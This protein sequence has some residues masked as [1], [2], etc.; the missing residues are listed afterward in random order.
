MVIPVYDDGSVV[1]YHADCRTVLAEIGCVADHVITD[2]PYDAHTHANARSGHRDARHV[3][4]P[5]PITFAPLDMHECVPLLLAAARRWCIC[6]CSLEMIGTYKAIAGDRFVRAG[7]YRRRNGAPQFTGDRPAQ[8]GEG[9]A[10]SHALGRKR[11]NGGGRSG[12][13]ESLIVD[14]ETRTH[15]TQKPESLMCALIADFTD[16]GDLILDPFAGSGTTLVAAKRLGRRAIGIEMD[17]AYCDHI[18]ERLRQCALFTGDELEPR[19]QTLTFDE[20]QS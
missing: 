9:L 16:P 19:A 8:P 12:F 10:I 1:L 20:V 14:A 13:Y 7:F 11:W 15:P 2:P 3:V 18:I 6:F 4:R 17:R 5:L